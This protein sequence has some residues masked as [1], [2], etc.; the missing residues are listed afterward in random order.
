MG[1]GI[2]QLGQFLWHI[3]PALVIVLGGG[4]LVNRFFVRKANLGLL[5]DRI[6]TQLEVLSSDCTE[7]WCS[8]QSELG[9]K[10]V[11][12]EAKLKARIL[13]LHSLLRVVEKKYATTH[14]SGNEFA[15]QI[16]D[17]QQACT[18]GDFEVAERAA[19]RKQFM[20]AVTAIHKL[21][22]AILE[23]KL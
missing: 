21:N 20:K 19:D 10:A 2:T 15:N 23:K 17:L 9:E 11:I 18:G 3:T 7:Y 8:D 22:T 4:F 13:H 1:S 5:V 12:L 16:L 14:R 6:A